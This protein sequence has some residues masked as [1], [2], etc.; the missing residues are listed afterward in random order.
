[1]STLLD[2]ASGISLAYRSNLF[3]YSSKSAPLENRIGGLWLIRIV[4][5]VATTSR[6]SQ[7]QEQCEDSAYLRPGS[8]IIQAHNSP[9]T[10]TC[11]SGTQTIRIQKTTSVNS[12]TKCVFLMRVYVVTLV[13]W[14]VL[15]V[16]K[17]MIILYKIPF[18]ED[19]NELISIIFILLVLYWS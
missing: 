2:C 7:F 18:S 3:S 10:F 8:H 1:M 11:R 9:Y 17:I 15:F 14:P 13:T 5:G 6:P 12:N 16:N 19:K 4:S